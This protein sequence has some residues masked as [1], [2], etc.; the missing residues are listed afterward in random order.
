M[1]ALDTLIVG[2]GRAG[3]GLH[4]AAV[5][6][7]RELCAGEP[8]FALRPPVAVDPIVARHSARSTADILDVVDDVRDVANPA[9]T[10]VHI[11]VPP[12]SHAAALRAVA[13]AGFRKVL[14][15]K[16]L[17]TWLPE[18]ETVDRLV[19][20]YDLDIGVVSPW[21]SSSL[22]LKLRDI[23]RGELL[24]NLCALRI[25]QDKPRFSRTRTRGNHPTAFEV[26]IPHSLSLALL[27]GG[28]E[29]EV[30]HA[31]C[32][33]MRIGASVMPALGGASLTVQHRSGVLTEIRSDLT[34]PIR[35]RKL[36]ARFDEGTVVGHYS[37]G[38][39]DH[40]AQLELTRSGCSPQPRE[41][42]VDEPFPRLVT[43][44]Y[45]Y[46]AGIGARPTSDLEFNRDVVKLLCA[47][48]QRCGLGHA[49]PEA[50]AVPA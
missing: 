12:L 27:L 14:V 1:A 3:R 25:E 47:A 2:A 45:R 5:L 41:V 24:G 46:Y 10:V 17:V 11:C 42:F 50:E 38:S 4:L 36:T 18:M 29:A 8:V 31:T 22:T 23:I 28:R 44:W 15:E 35:Q 9:D 19:S 13:E 16:P 34:S 7:A 37:V 43:Q 6:R 30:T 21:L 32:E 20:S 39:D 26:E 33:D 49:V 48:K 40:Y